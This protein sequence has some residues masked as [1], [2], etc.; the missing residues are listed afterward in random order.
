M[1]L[2][3]SSGYWCTKYLGKLRICYIGTLCPVCSFY[4]YWSIY[5]IFANGK[6]MLQNGTACVLEATTR[7]FPFQRCHGLVE[8][9]I[10]CAWSETKVWKGLS[11]VRCILLAALQSSTVTTSAVLTKFFS[12]HLAA[13]R[14]PA[15]SWTARPA[16]ERRGFPS[17]KGSASSQQK[18]LAPNAL[19]LFLPQEGS[20]EAFPCGA[21][22]LRHSLH[23]GQAGAGQEGQGSSLHASM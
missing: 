9:G 10:V 18:A 13:Y 7:L 3:Y 5:I 12:K 2:G 14:P 21:W 17:G 8:L 20:A 19:F 1:A 11:W 6:M 22:W 16:R 23:S 15:L 4:F